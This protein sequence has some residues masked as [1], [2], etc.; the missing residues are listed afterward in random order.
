MLHLFLLN[1]YPLDTL[2]EKVDHRYTQKIVNLDTAFICEHTMF[3]TEDE[4][5]IFQ[6][7]F[8]F[9]INSVIHA[10]QLLGILICL[11]H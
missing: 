8:F 10:S 2:D 1:T 6:N 11:R 3:V 5:L 9:N 7:T 4:G